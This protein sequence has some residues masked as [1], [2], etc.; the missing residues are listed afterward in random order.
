MYVKMILKILT[1]ICNHVVSVKKLLINIQAVAKK[2]KKYPPEEVR[3]ALNKSYSH[4][5]NDAV[6]FKCGYT[7]IIGRFN[8][9]DETLGCFKDAFVLTLDHK[10]PN[11][12]ELVVSLNIINKM[13]CDIP[14]EEFKELIVALAD[15]YKKES[16]DEIQAKDSR[17]L[18]MALIEICS[19]SHEKE[20]P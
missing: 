5:E 3:K 1:R 20:A 4:K 10:Y 2:K 17:T 18:E 11:Q 16:E 12:K 15:F 13:K 9:N 7:G 8:D 6:Y 14:L 19:T